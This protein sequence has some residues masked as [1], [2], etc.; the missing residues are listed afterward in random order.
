[1]VAVKLDATA[2][3]ETVNVVE[4]WPAAIVTEEGTDTPADVLLLESVMPRPPE[5]AALVMETVR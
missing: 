5:G 4:V 1:M 3:V 2:A